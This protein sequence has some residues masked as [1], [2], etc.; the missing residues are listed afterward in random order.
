MNYF[1]KMLYLNT[2]LISLRTATG[3]TVYDSYQS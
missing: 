1:I 3:Y 2:P